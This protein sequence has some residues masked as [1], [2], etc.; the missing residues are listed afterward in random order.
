M[1]K[2]HQQFIDQYLGKQVEYHSYSSG[3][4]YQCVDLANQYIIDV[5]ELTPV[6]GTDAKDFPLKINTSEF[7]VIKNTPEFLPKQGDIAVWNGRVGGGAGHI[8]VVRDGKATLTTFNSIDQNW[9]K[10]LYVTLEAHNYS[11]VSSFLRAKVKPVEKTYSEAEMTAV[12]LERDKN[13]NLYQEIKADYEQQKTITEETKKELVTF[14]ETLAS[15]LT[16]VVDKNEVIGAVE[17]LLEVEN[18]RDNLLKEKEQQEKKHALERDELKLEIQQLREEIERQQKQN[19]TLLGRID[20]METKMSQLETQD[21]T[22]SSSR[23]MEWIKRLFG[24]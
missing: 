16:T 12:R 3:A 2:S 11:N 7:E 10:P 5:L 23:V 15:K 9:S 19:E 18:Q 8:A 21:V 4:K 14:M 17:R 6:I 20:D 22:I 13:W 1:A 24:K